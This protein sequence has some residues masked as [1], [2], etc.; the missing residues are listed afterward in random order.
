MNPGSTGAALP[1]LAPPR[2]APPLE[3]VDTALPTGLRVVA[4]RRATVPVVQL[5]L[6]V[7][8]GGSTARHT[9]AAELLACTLLT[10]GGGAGRTAVD[11]EL[12]AVGGS[13]R[14]VV[15]P[16]DLRI[17]GQVL[18]EGLPRLLAL[19][20]GCLTGA[21]YD[22]TTLEAE[23]ERLLHRIRL[24]GSMPA[25][26]AR[27]ALL[28]RC[29]G[30][31]PATRETP[32]EDQVAA[33]DRN[34][35]A[36]LHRTQLVPRGSA[37][38]LVGDIHPARVV[39]ELAV[40]LGGWAAG[41]Q[42]VRMAPLPAPAHPGEPPQ[43]VPVTGARQC[44]AR[45]AAPSL[46]RTDPGYPALVLADRVFGGYFSSRLV[47]RLRER[48]GRIYTGQSAI[49]Q[50][51]G[52]AL[53]TVQFAS[54]PRHAAAALDG[55]L[56]ELAAISGELPPTTEEIASARGH[57]LGL[58]ALALSTQKGLAD[59]LY[60]PVLAGLPADWTDHLAARLRA[61][62]D[63]EV[64]AAAADHLRP[65]AYTAVLLGPPADPDTD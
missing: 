21:G 14:A 30:D 35:V 31:H 46:V 51:T 59:S 18:T 26:A 60:G 22:G 23:R 10:G 44:E 39:E 34:E 49:E 11:D 38:V 17:T 12:A 58:Q 62:P 48:E 37:L 19:L 8:F 55:A 16:E 13:L 64:R 61:V 41:P 52:S 36:E 9:A 24:T 3:M 57:A 25:R 50:R 28:R 40:A 15:G 29:F 47:Q 45:L 5:R 20:A 33:V 6:G 32:T 43:A 42:A 56:A 63:D 54:A 1:P 7:P 4:A 27:A 53:G 2:P 65:D